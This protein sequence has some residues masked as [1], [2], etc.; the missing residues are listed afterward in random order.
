MRPMLK[1]FN[2]NIMRF[3]LR[4][5]PKGYKIYTPIS[6]SFHIYIRSAKRVEPIYFEFRLHFYSID[7][8]LLKVFNIPK[9]QVQLE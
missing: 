6:Y 2:A 7:S 1:L 4:L 8:C 3:S 5:S 9:D